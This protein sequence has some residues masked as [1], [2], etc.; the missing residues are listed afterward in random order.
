MTNNHELNCGFSIRIRQTSTSSRTH[1]KPA[2]SYRPLEASSGFK[3]PNPTAQRQETFIQASPKKKA[4][5][6][7]WRLLDARFSRQTGRSTMLSPAQPLADTDQIRPAPAGLLA[8]AFSPT[9]TPKTRPRGPLCTSPVSPSSI[10]CDQ[11]SL[12]SGSSKLV[13]L[14][15][16]FD[17]RSPPR[18]QMFST[19]GSPDS[20]RSSPLFFTPESRSADSSGIQSNQARPACALEVRPAPAELALQGHCSAQSSKCRR[21]EVHACHQKDTFFR[22]SAIQCC[23]QP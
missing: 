23:M 11:L 2:F 20:E 9:R 5:R 13:S 6:R 22:A 21:E 1:S 12:S 4:S 7:A 10:E 3:Q 19:G 17:I 14:L 8:S 16:K 18:G 15:D